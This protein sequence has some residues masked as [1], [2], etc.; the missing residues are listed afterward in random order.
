MVAREGNDED[1][2]K[3]QSCMTCRASL[4]AKKIPTIALSNGL[5]F[6]EKVKCVDRLSRLEEGLVAPRHIFQYLLT[7]KGLHGQFGSKGAIVNVPVNVDTSVS[8]LP[9]NLYDNSTVHTHLAR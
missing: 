6:P 9:R 8:S 5:H 7:H 3:Y 1:D 2:T 4:R